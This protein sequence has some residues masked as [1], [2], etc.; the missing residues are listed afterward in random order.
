[1]DKRVDEFRRSLTPAVRNIIDKVL[2]AELEK[3]DMKKPLGIKN[4]IRRIIQEEAKA[5]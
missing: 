2:E 3:L 4:E 1:M 5:K